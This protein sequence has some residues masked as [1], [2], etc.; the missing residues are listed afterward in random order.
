[1]EAVIAVA[2]GNVIGNGSELPW[3]RSKSDM[4]RFRSITLN[5]T[6]VMGRKTFE[7]IGK[8]LPHRENIVL[9]RDLN[10]QAEGVIITSDPLSVPDDSIIIGGAEIYSLFESRID[11]WH[12]SMFTGEH[13][14]DVVYVLPD[15]TPTGTKWRL[16]EFE[17]SEDHVYLRYGK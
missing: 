2:A 5:N 16:E 8:P 10:Y 15:R 1:M 14:G 9:T 11:T 12:V 4:K 7:S 17:I 3:P 6:I 13:L